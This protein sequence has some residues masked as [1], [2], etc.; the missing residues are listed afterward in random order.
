MNN[1]NFLIEETDIELAKDICKYIENPDIR[2]RA[3][4]NALASSVAEKYFTEIEVDSKT[5][6]HNISKVLE[7]IE[8]SDIYANGSYIDVRFY[9]ENEQLTVPKSTFDMGIQPV[10]YMFIKL[11]DDASGGLVTGFIQPSSISTDS[12]SGNYYLVS[13]EDLVSFYD[14]QPLLITPEEVDIPEN[15]SK[16]VFDFL[17]NKHEAPEQFY[18]ILVSS[19]E[20]REELATKANVKNIFKFVSFADVSKQEL[21]PNVSEQET[22]VDLSNFEPSDELLT[23]SDTDGDM[24]LISFD[25][26]DDNSFDVVDDGDNLLDISDESEDVVA[27]D[28][29][30][31]SAE[32]DSFELHNDD[33]SS[34]NEMF[35]MEESDSTLLNEASESEELLN[36]DND[37]FDEL[38]EQ[39]AELMTSELEE[40]NDFEQLGHDDSNMAILEEDSIEESPVE[41][42]LLEEFPLKSEENDIVESEVEEDSHVS[43]FDF[44]T[45]TTPSLNEVENLPVEENTNPDDNSDEIFDDIATIVES[46]ENKE[47]NEDALVEGYDNAEQIDTLFND[48]ET[49]EDNVEYSQPYAPNKQKSS[50]FGAIFGILIL[51]AGL[52]CAGYFG[53]TKYLANGQFADILG[54]KNSSVTDDNLQREV[55]TEPERDFEEEIP[56]AMPNE[57]IE[58]VNKPP[59]ITNEGTAVSIPAIEQNLDTTVLVSNLRV[60]WEVPASYVSNSTAKRYFTKLGKIIQ[61][62]LKTELLLLTKQPVSN[63]IAVELQYDKDNQAYSVKGI[64]TSSGDKDVD[65]IVV[66][67][68]SKVL[69][70]NLKVNSSSFKTLSGNP[71]LVINF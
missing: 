55:V 67:T 66:D 56:V 54:S 44:S 52:G 61:L 2:N 68:V 60:N 48:E 11:E 19:Q 53:Y 31:E 41:E 70:M 25:N 28:L 16:Q 39:S 51:L 35:L 37:S 23:L 58:N 13:E 26:N 7:N 59:A 50:A 9:F 4:A 34:E 62:H 10:A 8:I 49:P 63:K 43:R 46:E 12:C 32:I 5:G 30:E 42:S 64:V 71:V 57:T 24:E 27:T 6:I 29:V 38:E 45:E 65:R 69:N 15:F 22:N 21:V 33:S 47:E 18:K 3:V 1:D 17:D 14:I 36:I 20:A 40:N